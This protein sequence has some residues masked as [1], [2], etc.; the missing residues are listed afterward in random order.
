LA[1]L[2]SILNGLAHGGC[3]VL[4][5]DTAGARHY[6]EC[7]TAKSAAAYRKIWWDGSSPL[8]VI[9]QRGQVVLQAWLTEPVALVMRHQ[10]PSV[11][12]GPQDVLFRAP[13]LRQALV[14]PL[15]PH[16]VMA[17]T[18]TVAVKVRE[19]LKRRCAERLSQRG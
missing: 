9:S 11:E 17:T 16:H 18:E 5:A 7:A 2:G 6:F 3:A 14:E 4:V 10:N 12:A 8:A 19:T 13:N 1:L 15:H